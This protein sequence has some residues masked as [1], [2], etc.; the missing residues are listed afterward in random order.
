MPPGQ[1]KDG[2]TAKLL[3]IQIIV[4]GSYAGMRSLDFIIIPKCVVEND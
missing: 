4:F 2:I 3:M 1:Y